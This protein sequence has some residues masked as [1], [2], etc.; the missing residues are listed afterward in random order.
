MY[1]DDNLYDRL[2]G[3]TYTNPHDDVYLQELQRPLHNTTNFAKSVPEQTPARKRE[4]KKKKK[5]I[6]VTKATARPTSH[7]RAS[8]LF[9]SVSAARLAPSEQ[10]PINH[11][12]HGHCR[13]CAH[14]SGPNRTGS[15]FRPKITS[16][17]TQPGIYLPRSRHRWHGR[18]G[19]SANKQSRDD[20]NS[21]RRLDFGVL[22]PSEWTIPLPALGIGGVR[23]NLV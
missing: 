19:Q 22:C 2:T 12:R 10:I 15:I 14:T 4:K 9:D 7:R 17:T 8:H 16:H 20:E 6:S 23:S 21:S 18:G 11:R 13:P 5:Q 3:F 1:I